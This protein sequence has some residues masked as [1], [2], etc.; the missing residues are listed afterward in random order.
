[1]SSVSSLPPTHVGARDR[2]A[3]LSQ[4]KRGKTT[5]PRPFSK[6]LIDGSHLAGASIS[7]T[8]NLTGSSKESHIKGFQKLESEPTA[9]LQEDLTAVRVQLLKCVIPDELYTGQGYHCT[10]TDT[11]HQPKR[12]P[13]DFNSSHI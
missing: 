4:S 3:S 2:G 8:A 11:N 12:F 1:M 13:T 10:S 6:E 9:L 7:K 5:D